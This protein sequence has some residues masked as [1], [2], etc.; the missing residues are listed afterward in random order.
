MP[1]H[2][3]HSD[4]PSICLW[5]WYFL[6][7]A[8]SRRLCG[9]DYGPADYQPSAQNP[10][11]TQNT[12]ERGGVFGPY[13]AGNIRLAVS[14]CLVVW[15]FCKANSKSRSASLA[16]GLYPRYWYI[17]PSQ[18]QLTPSHRK[19]LIPQK[20]RRNIYENLFKGSGCVC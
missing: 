1:V 10:R 11:R 14:V 16:P 5:I 4:T 15:A 12:P 7:L 18:T 2:Y 20:N 3:W 6:S 19:M 13:S 17:H 9:I 8:Y